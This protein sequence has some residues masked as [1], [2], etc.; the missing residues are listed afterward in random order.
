ME[1]NTKTYEIGY[2][3]TPLVSEEKLDE[4]VSVLRKLIE[5]QQCFIMGEERPKMRK[6]AYPIQKFDTA[7]FGWIKFVV[8]PEIAEKVKG[9][10]DGA[11]NVLR[12]LILE[13]TK[14]DAIK[15]PVKKFSKPFRS[16]KSEA[17][18]AGGEVRV[19]TEV[20]PEEIDKK[21]EELLGTE[22]GEVKEVE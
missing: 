7:Y 19:K 16:E 18:S 6:L 10:F 13:I 2:L 12:F 22:G 9:A 4:E 5:D 20:K 17:P 11:G 1:N 15:K 14:E 21:I 8:T 3:L